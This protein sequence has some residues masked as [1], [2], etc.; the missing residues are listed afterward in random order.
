MPKAILAAE[1]GIGPQREEEMRQADRAGD[2]EM[3]N[4][5]VQPYICFLHNYVP[6]KCLKKKK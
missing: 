1:A 3:M 2:N 4:K 6:P 5:T